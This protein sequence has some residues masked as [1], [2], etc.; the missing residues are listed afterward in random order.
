MQENKKT[1]KEKAK[2]VVLWQRTMS[3]ASTKKE[4]ADSQIENVVSVLVRTGIHRVNTF[5]CQLKALCCPS[6]STNTTTR[7]SYTVHVH[8][9]EIE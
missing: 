1:K 5:L 4:T 3:D 8:S 7:T 9:I 6:D 2:Q